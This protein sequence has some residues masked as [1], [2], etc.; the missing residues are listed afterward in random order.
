MI[1]ITCYSTIVILPDIKQ[2]GNVIYAC[3]WQYGLFFI[4][5]KN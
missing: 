2:E 3:H 4:N 5:C 1:L